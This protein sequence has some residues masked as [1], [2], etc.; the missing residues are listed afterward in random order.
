[1]PP[2]DK[3]AT[4][5]TATPAAGPTL[6]TV[7]DDARGSAG[8]ALAEAA[9]EA[10]IK[11]LRKERDA[12]REQLDGAP[13]ELSVLRAETDMLRQ[14]AARAGVTGSGRISEG[15]RQDLMAQGRAADPVT[16]AALVLTD[17]D[18]GTVTVTDRQG[19]VSTMR[20]DPPAP[21]EPDTERKPK[22]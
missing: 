14:A 9:R 18:K 3:D 10:E 13:D 22:S 16:G 11:Q 12:L 15:V 19:N 7:Q 1:M 2:K 5:A 17:R 6:T 4:A 21:L 20:L 8:R